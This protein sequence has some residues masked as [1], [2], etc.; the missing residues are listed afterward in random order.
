MEQPPVIVQGRTLVPLRA[1]MESIG[2]EVKWDEATR[3]VTVLREGHT[4]T[5]Q[6]ASN[7]AQVDD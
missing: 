5:L 1:I 3:T 7:R 4:V 2:A 6:V